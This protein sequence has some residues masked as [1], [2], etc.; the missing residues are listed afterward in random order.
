MT[1]ATYTTLRLILGDQLNP[2]HS[3]FRQKD[4]RV[5]YVIAELHQEMHYV[6][7]HV[8]K[9]CAFFAAMA[10][11]AAALQKAGHQ[12]LYLTLDETVEYRHLPDL[13]VHLLERYS[14]HRF[15]YQLPD[16]FRLQQ[17]LRQ[18]DPGQSIEKHE[19]ETEHFY[20][21][22]AEIG[23]HFQPQKAQRMETFYRRMRKR[24]DVL[25]RGEEPESG[26]WNY[27]TE[28]R[29]KLGKQDLREVPEPLMFAN[30]VRP[31]LQRLRR[32]KVAHFGEP[33]EDL[34][35]PVNRRQANRLLDYFCRHCLGHFGRFQDAMTAAHPA[36]W[37]LYHSRLSFA[38]NSKMLSPQQ[39]VARAVARYREN[40]DRD[41]LA[42]VE[43][44]VRQ[45]LGWR[46]FVRGIYWSNM[47]GYAGKNFL[48]ATRHLPEYFWT[49]DTGM[50]CMKAALGQSLQY[51]YAHH[52]Q[53]L[54]V[55]G[56]FCL[57]TGM[58]P[59][60][61]DAWY[62]G[63]YVDAIE[64]V[65]MPN[66]RG[67]SQFADGGLLAS[68]PYASSG[69]YIHKTSDYCGGCAYQVKQKTGA[70]AC[71]FNSLYWHFMNRHRK[72]FERNPRVGMIFR[73]WDKQAEEEREAV[74]QRAQ[75]C[76]DNLPRL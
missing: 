27:D 45:I 8:Q 74:L 32:H 51:A 63:V 47:P 30:D 11:F 16:E 37:S 49:G 40:R 21:P 2:S 28:N 52:I 46:E 17:Q 6:K 20:L 18:F 33:A 69:H 5:L 65:E 15:D 13:L 57:L 67:M 71:P 44:F 12:V 23:E 34:L 61:V 72:E 39:V 73:N 70:D 59:D 31:I 36:G 7:H 66:T 14:I 76:L 29:H 43:G 64:W 24:F 48:R 9:I 19:W 58:D 53:R 3:W 55:I 54:M 56:N 50:A 4:R 68:K 35:W 1:A 10:D 25:M 41:T 38:I 42:Q 22:F 62:L 26:R 60:E 75:W